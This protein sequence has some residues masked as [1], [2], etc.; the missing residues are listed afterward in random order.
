M[1]TS[2]QYH[3][4]NCGWRGIEA[5]MLRID[6]IHDRVS[7]GE[8]MAAGECPSC[9]DLISVADEDVPDYTLE[10]VAKIMRK[11]GWLV[12][13]AET[14]GAETDKLRVRIEADLER[15]RQVSQEPV[16]IRYGD[17]VQVE[18]RPN[19]DDDRV[20]VVHGSLGFVVANYQDDGVAIDVADGGGDIVQTMTA[21]EF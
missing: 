20:T 18:I 9:S 17:Q 11:R 10:I 2:T 3:C 5:E 14:E 6:D 4:G 15:L 16:L 7:T 12:T 1:T 13:P 19:T 8:L 21:T